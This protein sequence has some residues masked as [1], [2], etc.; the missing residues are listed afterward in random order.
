MLANADVRL[1][2]VVADT[3]SA[4]YRN[5]TG[6]ECVYV[7]AGVATLET[8]FGALAVQ[9]GDF[10]PITGLVHQPPPVHQVFEGTVS[11]SARSSRA[12]S[13]T[14]RWRCR[15]RTTTPTST[16]TR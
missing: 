15:S 13:T 12:R 5:A 9:A 7:E 8:V 4:Y 6:D 3:V 14:T 11:S 16:V 2:Y 1:S 10:E